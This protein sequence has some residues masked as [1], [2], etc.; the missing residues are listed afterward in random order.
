V[1]LGR[2]HQKPRGAPKRHPIFFIKNDFFPKVSARLNDME[3]M[4]EIKMAEKNIKRDAIREAWLVK[5]AEAMRPLFNEIGYNLPK[6]RIS[7][8]FTG[9]KKKNAIGVCWAP[10]ASNDGTH[11]IFV[12]PNQ[13]EPMQVAAIVAHELTHAAVGLD[14]GHGKVFARVA[15]SLGLEGKMTATQPGAVFADRWVKIEGQVGAYPHA[16]MQFAAGTSTGPKKQGTRMLKACCPE[17]GYTVRTTAMW[18]E[19]A[20]PTCPDSNCNHFGQEME[21]D[22]KKENQAA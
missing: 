3:S 12:H 22:G 7:C 13:A 15:H 20:V 8:G 6:Y 11:E 21:V 4:E 19:I 2:H 16:A 18:L 9:S 10:A 17:C 5:V 1:K 14:K